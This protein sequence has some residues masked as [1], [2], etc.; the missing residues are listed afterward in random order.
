MILAQ[1][2]KPA[3]LHFN[4]FR[5]GV[6]GT[7]ASTKIQ[8]AWILLDGFGDPLLLYQQQ[9]IKVFIY[10]SGTADH[11]IGRAEDAR[12]YFTISEKNGNSA[13]HS[14]RLNLAKP[15]ESDARGNALPVSWQFA[16]GLVSV[17]NRECGD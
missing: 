4:V 2:A 6:V 5:K 3:A 11:Q 9:Y 17:F 8:P 15:S 7:H 14:L 16:A 12:F 10:H 13:R 1:A